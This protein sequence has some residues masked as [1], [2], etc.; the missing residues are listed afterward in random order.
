MAANNKPSRREMLQ[1]INEVSFAVV[2]LNLFLDT[3]PEDSNA[4]E[5]FNE[6]SRH[7]QKLLREYAR[8]YGPLIVDDANENPGSYWNWIQM[9]WPWQEGGC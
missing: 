2:E 7:R 6:C 1:K 5:Y 9:P 3:H 8:M 4:L